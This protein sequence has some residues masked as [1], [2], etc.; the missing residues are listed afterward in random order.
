MMSFERKLRN[1]TLRW[2]LAERRD[3]L[4]NSQMENIRSNQ[5]TNGT[6]WAGLVRTPVDGCKQWPRLAVFE[7]KRHTLM[8]VL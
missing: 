4:I 7:R 5:I 6:L 8:S 3:C 1:R 2:S